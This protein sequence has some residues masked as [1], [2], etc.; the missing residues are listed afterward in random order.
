MLVDVGYSCDV[1]ASSMHSSD[2]AVQKAVTGGEP[3][4]VLDFKKKVLICS[5]MGCI[6]E[7]KSLAANLG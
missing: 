7:S 6:V 1:L 3:R 4:I 2:Q 5:L